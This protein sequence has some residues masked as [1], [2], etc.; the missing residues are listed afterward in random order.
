MSFFEIFGVAG[1]LEFFKPKVDF[2]AVDPYNLMTNHSFFISNL[3]K[4]K[5]CKALTPLHRRA[6]F[7]GPVTRANFD[8]KKKNLLK[9]YLNKQIDQDF[10]Q[11]KKNKKSKESEKFEKGAA[12]TKEDKVTD[13]NTFDKDTKTL[14]DK[15]KMGVFDLHIHFQPKLEDVD[16]YHSG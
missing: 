8:E 5:T 2:H 12:D 6:G 15:I 14:V 7:Y 13:E 4:I 1:I 10:N 9:K 11:I 16:D 3:D